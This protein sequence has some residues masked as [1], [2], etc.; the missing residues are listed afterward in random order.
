MK[1][2]PPRYVFPCFFFRFLFFHLNVL[3]RLPWRI[4]VDTVVSLPSSCTT[5]AGQSVLAGLAHVTRAGANGSTVSGPRRLPTLS[6]VNGGVLGPPLA[7]VYHHGQA[8]GYRRLLLLCITPRRFSYCSCFGLSR[9][10]SIANA[11]TTGEATRRREYKLA[12]LWVS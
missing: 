10:F 1:S 2:C 8:E 7:G 11:H 3:R 5:V 9:L 4:S 12:T 6:S